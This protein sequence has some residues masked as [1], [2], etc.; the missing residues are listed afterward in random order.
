MINAK[1]VVGLKLISTLVG[2]SDAVL[3]TGLLAG[4]DAISLNQVRYQFLC[5]HDFNFNPLF[6]SAEYSNTSYLLTEMFSL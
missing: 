1:F 4:N 6:F 2:V 3:K 5:Y